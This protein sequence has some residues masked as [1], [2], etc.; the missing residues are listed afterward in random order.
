MAALLL[1]A[2]AVRAFTLPGIGC[3]EGVHPA[4][5]FAAELGALAV[6]AIVI[7][8]SSALVAGLGPRRPMMR[9]TITAALLAELAAAVWL[10]FHLLR[11]P[12]Y[13]CG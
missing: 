3:W 2:V 8:P 5:Y 1:S 6:A 9:W 11:F 13:D 10:L 4:G 7:V 12:I